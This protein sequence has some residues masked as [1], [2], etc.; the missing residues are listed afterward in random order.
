M[1]D[2]YV[3]SAAY[4]GVAAFVASHAYNIGDLVKPTAP[5]F[6]T[7][8][9]FR[10]I[11]AG[12]SSTEPS[13]NTANNGTSTS[14][15][16]TF[17]NVTGQSAYGWA[18]AAG[19]LYSIT[20]IGTRAV[21]GDRVFLSSDHSDS[22]NATFA[23]STNTGSAAFGLQQ[24]L[25][26]NRAGSVP[27]VAADLQN[28][29][30][31][32][33]PGNVLTIDAYCNLFWQGVTFS[34]GSNLN[35]NSSG[36][37]EAYF[38]YCAFVLGSN[39]ASRIAAGNVAKVIWDNC[40]VQFGNTS[41]GITASGGSFD[42]LWIN[43]PS[44]IVG[45]TLPGNLFNSSASYGM[46]AT[47]RGVDLS[48]ITGIL[49]NSAGAAVFSKVLLDSCKINGSVARFNLA[50][51]TASPAHDEIELVNCWDGTNVLNERHTAAGDITTDRTTYLTSGAQDDIGNYS[52]RLASNANNDKFAFPLGSFWLDVENTLTGSSHTATVEVMSSASLNNDDISLLLE[53]M[54]TSGSSV[55]SFISSLPATVLTAGSALSTS[56]AT[57]GLVPTFWN[58][59]D[60]VGAVSTFFTFSNNFLTAISLGAATAATRSNSSYGS[61]KYYFEFTMNSWTGAGGNA[62]GVASATANMTTS[63]TLQV[64]KLAQSGSIVINGVTQGSGLGA[65]ANAD[66]IG[67]AL[68]MT[69]AL[70]WFRVAPSGNWNG[71][72]TADPGTGTGGYSTSSLT[73]SLYAFFYGVSSNSQATLNIGSSAFIGT[74]PSGFTAGLP[75]VVPA[76][77]QK[78]QVT[79]TPQVAG[80]VRG[81]VRL[82]KP[83][84]MTWCNPQ[85]T[86][87]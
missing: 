77:A 35:F 25:S 22:I 59:S 66:V 16:A 82:G 37:K 27:P 49:L 60:L 6:N 75:S 46:L 67:V 28:G 29:A 55:A 68:D 52:L 43:T 86:V 24:F 79:F 51:N 18:A 31:I 61:G 20:N 36:T 57:W 17:T 48:A 83:S 64:G 78:L 26:V 10:C 76:N 73:G 38:K 3:S 56:T 1:A 71:S 69:N 30:S 4:A 44:A 85:I 5:T 32:S 13:W 9:V 87:T 11:T 50:S 80:R 41:Q 70:I 8:W 33:T 84:I 54:S 19:S 23:I 14:G 12:T 81:L 15:G 53:Y 34:A 7:S 2:W 47:C 45:G 63:G 62:V 65:R 21:V 74:V 58:P 40:T 72:G 39:S 42:L